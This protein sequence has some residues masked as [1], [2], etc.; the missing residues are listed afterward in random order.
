MTRGVFLGAYELTSPLFKIDL[1][2]LIMPTT[3]DIIIW[4]LHFL[5]IFAIIPRFYLDLLLSCI[6]ERKARIS[7][8]AG[9]SDYET[10]KA[11]LFE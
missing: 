11:P 7:S 3:L 4:G 8:L 1:V 2:V 9:V 6:R 5:A 10:A